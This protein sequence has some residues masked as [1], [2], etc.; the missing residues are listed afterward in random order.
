MFE[1][2]Y[3][4]SFPK[5]KWNELDT[6]WPE[7]I[8]VAEMA[9]A[10]IFVGVITIAIIPMVV[11]ACLTPVSCVVGVSMAIPVVGTGVVATFYFGKGTWLVFKEKILEEKK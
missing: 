6:D 2:D 7:L 10:T 8:H 4:P 3:R 1:N 9:G 5:I 11:S